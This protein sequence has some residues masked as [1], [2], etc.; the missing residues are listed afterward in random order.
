MDNISIDAF[1]KFIC[2]LVGTYCVQ[3]WK[4]CKWLEIRD[5]T[6][7][8]YTSSAHRFWDYIK[9]RE[10]EDQDELALIEVAESKESKKVKQ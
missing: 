3:G 4:T 6:Q 1:W 8:N 2:L 10:K 9:V 5:K 7:G